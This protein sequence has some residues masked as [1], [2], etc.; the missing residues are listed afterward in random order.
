MVV[1]YA[2]LVPATNAPSAQSL[3]LHVRAQRLFDNLSLD[4]A[5]IVLP[6]VAISELLVPVPTEDAAKLIRIL[7]ELFFCPVFDSRAASIAASL[8]SHHKRLPRDRQ[9]KN[10]HVL[11]ADV[12]I[13]ASAKAAGATTFYS[14]DRECR[15]LASLIMEADGLPAQPKTLQD[16]FVESDIRRGDSPPPVKRPVKKKSKRTPRPDEPTA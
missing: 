12:L 16:V 9:Y 3:E 11:K 5:T 7:Q 15:M 2:G 8:W 1:I 10:R 13:V 6:F 14:N 4:Q